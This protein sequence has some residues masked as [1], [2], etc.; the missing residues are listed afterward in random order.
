MTRIKEVY[1]NKL[2][3][4]EEIEKKFILNL[5]ADEAETVESLIELASEGKDEEE[6]YRRLREYN[7]NLRKRNRKRLLNKIRNAGKKKS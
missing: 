4:L 7:K 5:D 6:I 3:L 2:K 1:E